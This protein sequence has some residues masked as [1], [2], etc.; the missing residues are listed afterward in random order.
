MLSKVSSRD[1]VVCTFLEVERSLRKEEDGSL[2]NRM[3]ADLMMLSQQELFRDRK[4]AYVLPGCV[5]VKEA[6]VVISVG[7]IF[8]PYA[9]NIPSYFHHKKKKNQMKF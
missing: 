2:L 1:Q 5:I 6:T 8:D 3:L 7:V 9:D 4:H